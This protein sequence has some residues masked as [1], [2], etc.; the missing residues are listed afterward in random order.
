MTHVEGPRWVEVLGLPPEPIRISQVAAYRTDRDRLCSGRAGSGYIRPYIDGEFWPADHKIGV[1]DVL[2]T[3]LQIA[4]Q[5]RSLV[6]SRLALPAGV[7]FVVDREDAMN[8]LT[9]ASR[10][11]VPGDELCRRC[12]ARAAVVLL[13]GEEPSFRRGCCSFGLA[14]PLPTE[15]DGD[16]RRQTRPAAG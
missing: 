2:V 8:W 7:C 12:G 6:R 15:R 1:D 14:S 16:P 13:L 10:S 5:P 9:L 11:G 3:W 4:G